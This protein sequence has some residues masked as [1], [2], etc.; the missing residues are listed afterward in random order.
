MKDVILFKERTTRKALTADRN[1]PTDVHYVRYR[2]PTWKKR[3]YVSAFRA[4]RKV[5]IFNHLHDQGY[6]VL[7]ITSGF[8]TIRPNLYTK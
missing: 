1:I 2:K 7:E 3:Q 5:D 8:G 6:V 4:Y